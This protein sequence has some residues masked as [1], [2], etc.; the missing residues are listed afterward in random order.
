MPLPF[1]E[2]IQ[3]PNNRPRAEQRLQG[4]EK[5]LQGDAKYR[6]DYVRFMTEIIE[7]GYARKVKVEELTHQE[8]KV[9]YLPKPGNIRVVFA[10]SACYQ[11]ESQLPPI[12]RAWSKKQ[13]HWGAYKI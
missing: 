10:C 3:L 11:G 2:N 1:G 9:W 12:A 5:R 4:L 6:A 13:A 7:K 8:G